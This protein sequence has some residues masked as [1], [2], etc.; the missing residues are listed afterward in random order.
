MSFEY[1]AYTAFDIDTGE[2]VTVNGT[3]WS[4]VIP[5]TLV[6]VTMPD[7]Q[8]VLKA[9]IG[10]KHNG[11]ELVPANTLRT[12]GKPGQ[13]PIEVMTLGRYERINPKE[14]SH[15][16]EITHAKFDPW[17]FIIICEDNSYIK[18]V[19][20]VD[21]DDGLASME[22]GNLTVRELQVFGLLDDG[23]W[24]TFKEQEKEGQKTDAKR[25]GEQQLNQ[26]IQ[27]LGAERVREIAAQ[28]IAA[29]S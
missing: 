5:C 26:A 2:I 1:T 24:E 4:C 27:A 19:P 14:L 6:G 21:P 28:V 25:R 17:K 13:V 3:K 9:D 7:N 18:L 12:H 15:D 8:P 29:N 10:A 11:G 22:R 20:V 16:R 23:V